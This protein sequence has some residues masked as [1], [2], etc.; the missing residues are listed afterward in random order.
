MFYIF[1]F[2]G[3]WRQLNLD[4]EK[5][6]NASVEDKLEQ[7]IGQMITEDNKAVA[8]M[9]NLFWKRMEAGFNRE[10]AMYGEIFRLFTLAANQGFAPAYENLAT[11]GVFN[12]NFA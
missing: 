2:S 10:L 5:S 7:L 6:E 3:T 12:A 1:I 11:L 9:M 4:S 8:Y